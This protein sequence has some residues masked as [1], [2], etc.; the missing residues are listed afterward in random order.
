[1]KHH[2]SE[3]LILAKEQGRVYN[4]GKMTA[5]IMCPLPYH[6]MVTQLIEGIKI[7]VS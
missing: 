6:L 4:C 5:I 1:M 2:Q 7:P 3:V